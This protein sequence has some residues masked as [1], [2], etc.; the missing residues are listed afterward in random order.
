MQNCVNEYYNE[1][2]KP[3]IDGMLG[4][5]SYTHEGDIKSTIDFL[6]NLS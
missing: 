3:T 1:N 2:V 6:H 4:G 5:L